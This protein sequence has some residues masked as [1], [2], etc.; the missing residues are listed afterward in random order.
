M[1]TVDLQLGDAG[2]QPGF[3][4]WFTSTVLKKPALLQCMRYYRS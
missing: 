3:V 4:L 2:G 1:H